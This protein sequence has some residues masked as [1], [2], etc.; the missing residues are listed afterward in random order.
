MTRDE[1]IAF[2]LECEAKRKEAL[3]AALAEGKP[4][5]A[6]VDLAHD[7]AKKCWNAWAKELLA[8]R[9]TMRA[10]GR[11]AGSEG[12]WHGRAAADF[13]FC[14]FV[15]KGA[16]NKEKE[17]K[18]EFAIEKRAAEAGFDS[19]SISVEAE[20]IRFDGFL[21]LRDPWFLSAIF[22]GSAS[23]RSTTFTGGALFEST[24]FMNHAFF[25][26]ANFMGS[27]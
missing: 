3:A 6:A 8:E 9:E 22:T 17:A 12:D 20:V 13:S 27:T 1:T 26:N 10:N 5:L 18:A 7:A 25:A 15:N 19:K 16:A 2:F 23:F 11:W 4:V 14:L 24:A 21:F